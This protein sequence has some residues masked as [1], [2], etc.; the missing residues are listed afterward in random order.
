[1]LPLQGFL[2]SISGLLGAH[3]GLSVLL[4]S[5]EENVESVGGEEVSL[6]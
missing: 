4:F 5:K 2:L 1:M 3:T 6:A